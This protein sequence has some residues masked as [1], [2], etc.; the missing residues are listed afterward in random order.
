MS[1]FLS[2]EWLAEAGERLAAVP[3]ID[4]VDGVVQA[5]ITGGPHGK[6]QV[7]VDVRSARV[8]EV[9]AGRHSQPGCTVTV[10]YD[11]AVALMSREVS[12]EV[13]F[14]QGRT[15]VEGDHRLWLLDLLPARRAD[16]HR[17]AL[18]A[19]WSGTEA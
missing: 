4:G 9:V 16:A 19:L 7:Y 14:M 3:A 11:D 13:A 2:D 15:K 5:V 17:E 6:V 12:V 10:S 8:A 1:A 18:A